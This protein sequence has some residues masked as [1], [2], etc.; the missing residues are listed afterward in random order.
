MILGC[1]GVTGRLSDGR[2][3]GVPAVDGELLVHGDRHHGRVGQLRVSVGRDV[4]DGTVGQE[5]HRHADVVGDA[6]E[7]HGRLQHPKIR[8][9]IL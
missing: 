3:A 8:L 2:V 4:N 7:H 1:F 6:G 9:T 5:L